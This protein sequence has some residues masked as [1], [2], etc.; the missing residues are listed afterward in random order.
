[1]NDGHLMIYI[2]N[3]YLLGNKT[4]HFSWPCLI[5]DEIILEDQQINNLILHFGDW[6]KAIGNSLHSILI[7]IAK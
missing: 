6:Y 5:F 2:Y 1:M 7:Y 4:K 3:I